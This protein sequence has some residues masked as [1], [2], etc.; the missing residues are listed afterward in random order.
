MHKRHNALHGLQCRSIYKWAIIASCAICIAVLEF[1]TTDTAQEIG[2]VHDAYVG[3]KNNDTFA[4]L[5]ELSL[6][7]ELI[8]T[9]T[10]CGYLDM[11]LNWIEQLRSIRA[12]NF[13]VIA[14]D[15]PAYEYLLSY[16]P[17]NT[18]P[19]Y[20]FQRPFS[21]T[22]KKSAP[23]ESPDFKMCHRPHYL[24]ELVRHNF[25]AVWI[26]SDI[27]LLRNPFKVLRQET[28]NII[29]VDDEPFLNPI[30]TYRHYYCSCFVLVR[31]SRDAEALLSTWAHM[32]GNGTQNQVPLNDAL[33]LL[34]GALSW[35]IMPKRLYPSGFDA[36]RLTLTRQQGWESPYWIH[37]NWRVGN[38]AKEQFLSRFGL[39][40]NIRA[41]LH[42]DGTESTM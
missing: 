21:R 35:K 28:N 19:S 18:M 38:K 31:P 41:P 25:S 1:V 34:E 24:T 20:M 40:R 32:C 26:D 30:K 39:W 4:V 23:F 22:G 11:T 27:A 29:L 15:L 3:R 36:E 37:A 16:A 7:S 9:A 8:V 2:F 10:T 13:L 14:E 33:D 42:C 12:S 5:K 17:R 6:R